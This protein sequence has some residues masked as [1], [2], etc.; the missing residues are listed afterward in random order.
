MALDPC[1]SSILCGLSASVLS[2]LQSILATQRA[3]VLEQIGQAQ[4]QL[5]IADVATLPVEGARAG[6]AAVL[7]QVRAA[8][9]L[10][11]LNLISGCTDLGDFNIGLND[12]LAAAN[13]ELTDI[14]DDL[15]ALLSFKNELNAII[16]NGNLLI[17]QFN[18]IEAVI[19]ECA[20]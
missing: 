14:T 9:Q 5:A 17:A 12:S 1:V 15:N 18:A 16:D 20:Q 6:A 2:A 11:P 13:A 7:E 3:V 8:A 10:V 19:Q 4:A